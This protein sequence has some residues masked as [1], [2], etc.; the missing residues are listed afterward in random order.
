MRKEVRI[1]AA[2]GVVL[3]AVVIVGAIVSSRNK[4]KTK[5]S[6]V[7]DATKNGPAGGTTAGGADR[8]PAP[9][10]SGITPRSDNADSSAVPATPRVDDTPPPVAPRSAT[11]WGALLSADHV[12]DLPA[13][14]RPRTPEATVVVEPTPPVL[15]DA[16][17]AS[18]AIPATPPSRVE[19]ETP[20]PAPNSTPAP[21]PA[22]GNAPEAS[23][24]ASHEKPTTSVGAQS[25]RIQSGET[26]ASLARTVY[27]NARY[28]NEIVKANPTVDPKHLRPGMVIT[29]PDPAQFKK[30]A[31]RAESAPAAP[32]EA[33]PAASRELPAINPKTEYRV[34]STDNLFKISNKLYNT[35]SKVDAIYQL[36]KE[37]I[38]S[39]P[40]KLKLN[41]VL[42]LPEPPVQA[43]AR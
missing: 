10:D 17:L 22:T 6:V 1:G 26:F 39:D 3:I 11:N 37:A 24:G 35:P 30:D 20:A 21:A 28:T 13:A 4:D 36:N 8:F 31:K 40:G 14:N 2:I 15:A 16:G 38:G 18:N 33:K 19:S 5:Q 7:L 43:A 27:G 12:E 25:H 29:L 42:K 34:Q 23:N 9:V 32:T 41:M